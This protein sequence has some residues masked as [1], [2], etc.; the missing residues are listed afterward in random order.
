MNQICVAIYDE[1]RLVSEG[2]K[3][4]LNDVEMIEVVFLSHN[5]AH[6]L[7]TL[8]ARLVNILLINIHELNSAITNLIIQ[9]NISFPKIKIL[10]MSHS[11]SE[12]LIL[13]TIKAGAKGFLARESDKNE[14]VEAVLTLRNGFDY[15]SKSI[16]HLLIN[17]YITKIKSEETVYRSD[18]EHL[19]ARQIEI[20]KLWGENYSNKEIA[21]KLFISIR[22]VE[23]HKNQIMQKLNLKTT[24]DMVKFAIRNNLIE[25]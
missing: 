3:S 12:D 21:D 15:Y 11:N 1:Q 4:L 23:T 2:M 9:L 8:R 14:L 18:V 19:S 25:I 16:T 17:K 22:T 6:L 24:V 5:K 13:K 10:I 7:E 20:L